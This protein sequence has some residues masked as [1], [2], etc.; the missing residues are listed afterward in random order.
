MFA[1]PAVLL[2][3]ARGGATQNFDPACACLSSSANI[4]AASCAGQW[5]EAYAF[6]LSTPI[7][8][9]YM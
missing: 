7:V 5:C 4:E 9:I 3:S 2:C 8:G 6:A 1:A